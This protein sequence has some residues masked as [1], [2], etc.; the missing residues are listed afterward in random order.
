MKIEGPVLRISIEAVHIE[1]SFDIP[2]WNLLKKIGFEMAY[3][4]GLW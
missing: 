3:T 4:E 2:G 1:D